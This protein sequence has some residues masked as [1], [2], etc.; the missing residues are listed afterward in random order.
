MQLGENGLIFKKRSKEGKIRR[1]RF[2]KVGDKQLGM[3][4]EKVE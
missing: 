4:N 3:N 2:K 1:G